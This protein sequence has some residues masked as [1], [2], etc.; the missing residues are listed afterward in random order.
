MPTRSRSKRPPCC[1]PIA[2]SSNVPSNLNPGDGGTD[3][4]AMIFGDFS[5]LMIGLFGA[6]SIQVNPYTGQLAGTVRISIHQEVDVAVRNAV[7]F[8][9]TNEVSTA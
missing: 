4:S 9:I 3:A 2:F 8:A 5:Q 6:P 1:R 7:S